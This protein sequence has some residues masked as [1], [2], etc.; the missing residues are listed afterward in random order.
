MARKRKRKGE[1]EKREE[2]ALSYLPEGPD[3]LAKDVVVAVWRQI[4]RTDH[5]IVIR[6]KLFHLWGVKEKRKRE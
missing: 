6:P 3:A 1:E 5:V 2:G 4:G